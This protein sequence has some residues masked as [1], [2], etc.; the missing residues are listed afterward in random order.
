M[1]QVDIVDDDVG[2]IPE[3]LCCELGDSRLISFGIPLHSSES[4][5]IRCSK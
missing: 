1:F 4:F 2:L 3:C 5:R